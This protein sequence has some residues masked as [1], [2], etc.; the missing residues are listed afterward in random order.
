MFND[1][2]RHVLI[3]ITIP[4]ALSVILMSYQILYRRETQFWGLCKLSVWFPLAYIVVL[5]LSIFAKHFMTFSKSGVINNEIYYL[6][7]ADALSLIKIGLKITFSLAVL[8][9][10]IQSI[11]ENLDQKLKKLEG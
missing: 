7:L 11:I 4:T 3:T 8:L 2:P 1:I 5:L 9:G 10:F 6:A